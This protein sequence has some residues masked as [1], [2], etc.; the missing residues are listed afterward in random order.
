VKQSSFAA[1]ALGYAAFVIYGSLVPLD[2][3]YRPLGEAWAAFLHTPYLQLGVDSRADW[4]ANILLYIPLG[5]LA[6]GWLA[7]R[8]RAVPASIFAWG[9]CALLA[10]AVEFTQLFFAPR[11]VSLNDLV[12]E[13]IGAGLGIALWHSAGERLAGLWQ[14]VQRGGQQGG[15][16]LIALY[17]AAYVGFSLF[18]YDFLVSGAELAQKLASPGS[19]AILF[20]ES[21]GSGLSCGVKLLAE[22]LTAAPL[23]AFLGMVAASGRAPGLARA[24]GWGVL[25]GIVIEGLQTFLASGISQGSSI[26]TRGL[27]MALGLAIHR[28]FRKEW[29]IEYRAPIKIVALSALPL[30]LVLLLAMIGFFTSSLESGWMALAKL[31]QV[32]FLPFYYHY[33][34]SETQALHSLLLHA[35]AYA[36]IGFVVWILRNGQGGPASLLLSAA[37]AFFAAAAMEAL[38]LF[39]E[40]RR[41]DPTDALIAAAAAALACFAATRLAHGSQAHVN[42]SKTAPPQIPPRP[43]RPSLSA[44]APKRT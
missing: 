24:F 28:F 31:Q 34:S 36:P 19:S 32:R 10:V 26:L 9:L 42:R 11:T 21:C 5:F 18:P 23:G 41:P 38:K 40:G 12:A 17:T 2:F 27:G 35:G 16:A 8:M 33:F 30:Y 37:A 44:A 39:L 43:R 15:R 3:H 1:A 25:L 14:A 29:L 20:T 4:V 22:V 7:A 6:G 13:W